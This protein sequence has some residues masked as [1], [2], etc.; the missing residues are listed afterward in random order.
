MD[1]SPTPHPQLAGLGAQTKSQMPG[2]VQSGGR[3]APEL[4]VKSLG[5]AVFWKLQ[6]VQHQMLA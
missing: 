6:G 5:R 4:R 3:R 2:S 1:L